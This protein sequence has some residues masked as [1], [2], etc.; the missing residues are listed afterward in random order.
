MGSQHGARSVGM[1]DVQGYL[2]YV[3]VYLTNDLCY[4]GKVKWIEGECLGLFICYHDLD[5]KCPGWLCKKHIPIHIQCT[6]THVHAHALSIATCMYI[7]VH[8]HAQHRLVM[9]EVQYMCMPY[10]VPLGNGL[11]KVSDGTVW[12]VPAITFAFSWKIHL[13]P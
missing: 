2:F 5:E 7:Y 8:V 6:N 13:M 1:N 11:I 10:I 4:L 9:Q 12:S 3:H